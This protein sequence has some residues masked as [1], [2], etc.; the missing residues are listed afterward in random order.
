LEKDLNNCF[1]KISFG[2]WPAHGHK[3]LAV[4]LFLFVGAFLLLPL[5]HDVKAQTEVRLRAKTKSF[6]RLP[7]ELKPCE[8]KD[9]ATQELGQRVIDILDNDL[10]MSSMVASY[11]SEESKANPEALRLEVALNRP[12]GPIR[13]AVQTKVSL[14]QKNRFGRAI[15]G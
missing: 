7:I 11:Q 12:T 3:L 8:L 2:C 14:V 13:L 9:Q 1:D 4:G 5:N 10:W 15:A 6:V